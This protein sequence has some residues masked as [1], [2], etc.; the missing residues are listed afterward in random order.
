MKLRNLIATLV[1]LSMGAGLS[2]SQNLADLAK[3]EK[4]R[5][6][7][8]K[9]KKIKVVTNADLKKIKIRPAVSVRETIKAESDSSETSAPSSTETTPLPKSE[10]PEIK[11]DQKSE[12][13]EKR[14]EIAKEKMNFLAS[15]LTVLWKQYTSAGNTV[16][17]E[18]LQQ[19][20][21]LTYLQLQKARQEEDELK[22]QLDEVVEK[23]EVNLQ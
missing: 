8:L 1:L 13:L 18:Y 17:R 15:Q 11:P 16:P 6:E 10:E 20:I 4:A 7:K 5:R 12:D 9:G 3:K 21:S 14:W 19:Q 23:K 22:R 2:S